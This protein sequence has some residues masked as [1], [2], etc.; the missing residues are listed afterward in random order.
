MN[1]NETLDYINSLGKFRLPAGLSRMKAVCEKLKNPQDKFKSIHIAGTNGKGSTALF[2]ANILKESGKKVGL[3]ISPFVVNFRER[4]QI[5]GEYISEADAVKCS[6]KV[7]DTGIELNAFEFITA[8]SFLYFFEKNVDVAVIETGLGGRFDATNVIKNVIACVITKIGLDHTLLLGE[9]V[10]QIADEKCGIIKSQNVI[11]VPNQDKAALSVIKGY[12]HNL[13]VPETLKIIS[14][15]LGGTKFSFKGKTYE[16]GLLGEHQAIN[17]VTA[18]ST[19]ESLKY[20]ISYDTIKTALKNSK[21][22]ARLE[23]VSSNPLTII[24]GAHNLD[25]A[26]VLAEFLKGLKEKPTV[27]IAMMKD[28]NCDGFLKTLLPNV[29]DCIVTKIENPRC[30]GSKELSAIASK[31]TKNIIKTD[32]LKDAILRAKSSKNPVFIT[33]SLYLASEARKYYI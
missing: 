24:D 7:I 25:G 15:D 21:F 13:L 14:A 10:E 19:V 22:P 27:I 31:Y 33:G 12:A 23:K 1:Y 16:T 28:K 9:T 17:A 11:T 4:I 30:M 29:K 32:N 18:I 5:N 2:I 3:Y 6:K 20:G 8:V 26:K